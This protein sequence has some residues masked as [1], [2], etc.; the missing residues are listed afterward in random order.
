MATLRGATAGGRP[1]MLVS[2]EAKGNTGRRPASSRGRHNN[3]P[4]LNAFTNLVERT[5]DAIRGANDDASFED[6]RRNLSDIKRH[7]DQVKAEAD[8]MNAELRNVRVE[9]AAMDAAQEQTPEQVAAALTRQDIMLRINGVCEEIEQ[10]AESK[11]VYDH[12]AQRLQKENRIVGEKIKRMEE[13]L[14]RKT[15]EMKKQQDRSRRL[16]QEKLEMLKLLEAK[17][18]EIE[19]ERTFCGAA[20]DDLDVTLQHQK[21]QVRHREEFEHWRYNVALEA[22]SEAF[23]ATAGR[24]RKMF[25]IEKMVG[26]CLQ[27]VIFEQAVQ[28]QL[29]EEGFQRIREV[30]GLTDVMDIVHKFL[31]REVEHE[32]LKNSVFDAEQQLHRLREVD[33]AGRNDD[34]SLEVAGATLSRPLGLHAEVTEEE[35]KLAQTMVEQEQLRDKLRADMLVMNSVCQWTKRVGRVLPGLDHLPAANS[36]DEMPAYLGAMSEAMER[37]LS[38]AQDELQNIGVGGK[39]T[40]ARHVVVATSREHEA[41]KCLLNDKEFL[42]LNNRVPESADAA[43][44]TGRP[45]SAVNIVDEDHVLEV[46]SERERLKLDSMNRVIDKDPGGRQLSHSARGHRSQDHRGHAASGRRRSA[47][48]AATAAGHHRGVAAGSGVAAARRASSSHGRR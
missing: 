39:H 2:S 41:M 35:T 47:L 5:V 37:I 45:L 18:E 9:I 16:H 8:Q 23:E 38:R 43:K 7:Y 6:L 12:M 42:R 25:A 3:T 24:F 1:M 19:L 22:A 40:S 13:H 31:N 27:K 46:Q 10:V 17:E 14:D 21:G 4:R 11:K 26:N 36:S 15:H 44:T 29:I 28:S 48:M 20:M 32:Q 34:R 33:Q 30:T